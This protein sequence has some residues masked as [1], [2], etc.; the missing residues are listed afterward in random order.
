M[1]RFEQRQFPIQEFSTATVLDMCCLCM[2]V[3]KWFHVYHLSTMG[4]R[5][6]A[7]NVECIFCGEY[8]L[9]EQQ[10]SCRIDNIAQNIF[11]KRK[12][13]SV[14]ASCP[15]TCT[16][17]SSPQTSSKQPFIH[18]GSNGHLPHSCIKDSPSLYQE[19]Y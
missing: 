15:C 1:K 18:T 7:Y 14:Y 19:K 10:C 3:W 16:I 6:E 5:V 8:A 12:F 11:W 13:P 4:H 17:K 9:S 2:Y